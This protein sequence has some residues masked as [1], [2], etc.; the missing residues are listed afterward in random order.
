[1][2]AYLFPLYS[3]THLIVMLWCLSLLRRHR[4]P[5]ALLTA[6]IAAGL[7]YDNGIIALGS[8]I[9]VGPILEALN[10]PRFVL[11][12][13][14]TPFM[15]IAVTQMAIAGGIRWAAGR[16]WQIAVWI[17]VIAGMAE[18]LFGHLLGLDLKPACFNGVVRYTANLNPSQ[19][20][21]DT[22]VASQGGGPPIPSIVGN[23]VTLII[24]FALW[25]RNDWIWLMTGSLVMFVAAAIPSSG[26]GLAPGNGGEVVLLLT[27]AFTVNRFG[28]RRTPAGAV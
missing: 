28:R 25:R 12:A 10:W 19:F 24:G 1:M 7:V 13:L 2:S 18:G 23:L 6:L 14:V 16:P 15:M 22:Q 4:A 26:F 21:S 5:G 8:S 11:H 3:F 17:L 9:G 27:Y 20:C